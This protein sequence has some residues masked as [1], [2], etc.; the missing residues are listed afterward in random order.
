MKAACSEEAWRIIWA[1]FKST[2]LSSPNSRYT[3]PHP[4]LGREWKNLAAGC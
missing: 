2:I 4:M 1:I 3:Q